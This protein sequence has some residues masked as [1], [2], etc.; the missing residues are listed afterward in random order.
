[1]GGGSWNGKNFGGLHTGAD[2]KQ[3]GGPYSNDGYKHDINCS[4]QNFIKGEEVMYIGSS[5]KNKHKKDIP[6]GSLG[7]VVQKNNLQNHL[8]KS[9][10]SLILVD[11]GEH[12]KR[13]VRKNLLQF[14]SDY[15]DSLQTQL[16]NIPTSNQSTRTLLRSKKKS[17]EREL[18]YKQ[19]LKNREDNKEYRQ[20]RKDLLD[21]K[22]I[23]LLEQSIELV[24][25][26]EY[27]ELKN[28]YTEKKASLVK[29]R[30]RYSQS[31][32]S[33][34]MTK[35]EFN[36]NKYIQQKINDG[37]TLE[38]ATEMYTTQEQKDKETIELLKTESTSLSNEIDRRKELSKILKATSESSARDFFRNEYSSRYYYNQML[39]QKWCEYNNVKPV[40]HKPKDRKV[41]PTV[42]HKSTFELDLLR[43]GLYPSDVTY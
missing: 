28:K 15:S 26:P 11:F 1:M 4:H 38:Q 21:T 9:S 32:L 23:E 3:N 20:F 19:T 34:N 35:E 31:K 42:K 12:G 41:T 16:D 8:Q 6:N 27:N 33:N 39:Y 25:S 22:K 36:K 10:R 13:Y 43:W 17:K 2:K 37:S 5:N 30:E 29:L 24:N 18:K 40:I 7:T 14:P